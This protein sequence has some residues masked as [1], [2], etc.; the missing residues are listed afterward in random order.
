MRKSFAHFTRAGHG[1]CLVPLLALAAC[2]SLPP[3]TAELDAA[4]QSVARADDADARQHAPRALD[5]ARDALSRAQ[6]AMSSGDEA[7]AR[8]LALLAAA[9]ADLAQAESRR[10]TAESELAQRRAEIATLRERLGVQP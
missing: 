2:A 7:A 8:S 10:A 6:A 5:T 9:S 1:L 3:P 4:A